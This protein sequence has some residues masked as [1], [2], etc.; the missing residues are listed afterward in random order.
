MVVVAAAGL[1]ERRHAARLESTACRTIRT[2]RVA[3][4]VRS[5]AAQ[6]GVAGRRHGPGHEADG[7]REGQGE[8]REEEELLAAARHV[9]C[10]VWVG[11]WAIEIGRVSEAGSMELRH[12]H[13][14]L[15]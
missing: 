10:C 15:Q 4:I 9:R 11:G 6:P 3:A 5:E 7:E 1:D 13:T 12:T 8:G 14:Y 2:H